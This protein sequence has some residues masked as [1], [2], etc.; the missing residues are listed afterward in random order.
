MRGKHERFLIYTVATTGGN[1]GSPLYEIKENKAMV[2]G[3][4]VAGHKVANTAVPIM[5]HMDPR[6]K[7]HHELPTITEDSQTSQSKI[8][9]MIEK[10]M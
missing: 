8:N 5:Y 6:E 7:L 10:L 4:H 3:V 1:S 9:H 2:I